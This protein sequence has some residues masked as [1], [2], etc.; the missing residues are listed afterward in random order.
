MLQG[1]LSETNLTE[2]PR[3]VIQEE[4][5]IWHFPFPLQDVFCDCTALQFHVFIPQSFPKVIYILL[6][7][8]YHQPRRE[9][10]LAISHM[11]FVEW[12][13]FL[14]HHNHPPWTPPAQSHTIITLESRCRLGRW[15]SASSLGRAHVA[16]CVIHR[17][18]ASLL[19]HT[20]RRVKMQPLQMCVV[21]HV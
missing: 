20:G 5:F 9:S 17:C 19:P 16:A 2:K 15:P 7:K 21:I 10:D 14:P 8:H 12:S 1:N 11:A 4:N 18:A 6:A 13:L 3:H